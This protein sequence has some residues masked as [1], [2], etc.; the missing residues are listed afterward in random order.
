MKPPFSFQQL[1]EMA[2]KIEAVRAD[3]MWYC[4]VA[5]SNT[6]DV[7]RPLFSIIRNDDKRRLVFSEDSYKSQVES[8]IKFLQSRR[9][10]EKER[11]DAYL[12]TKERAIAARTMQRDK[13]LE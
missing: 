11:L 1:K 12:A 3:N 2:D 8:G 4:N 7:R 13:A 6:R 5:T 9:R 10:Q